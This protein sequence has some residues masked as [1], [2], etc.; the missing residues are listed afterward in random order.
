MVKK[1][2]QTD[3]DD[4]EYRLLKETVEK[5]GLTIKSGLRDA[6]RQ[7]VRT[8]IPVAEDP[9]FKL[10]PVSTGVRTD[11]SKLDK[12]IKDAGFRYLT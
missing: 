1:V 6:I 2:V 10:K 4:N 5:R 7:W 8:Q 9:I 11:S 3:L 12:H